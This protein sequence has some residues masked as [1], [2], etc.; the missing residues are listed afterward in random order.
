MNCSHDR[1]SENLS[2][3]SIALHCVTAFIVPAAT[4]A[5][6]ALVIVALCLWQA[7][8]RRC[9][10]SSMP[11]CEPLLGPSSPLLPISLPLLHLRLL[12][13]PPSPP[14]PVEEIMASSPDESEVITDISHPP[15]SPALEA[16]KR[17]VRFA[18]TVSL[19]IINASS[20]PADLHRQDFYRDEESGHR[21]H[22]RHCCKCSSRSYQYEWMSVNVLPR[23]PTATII[24]Y[25]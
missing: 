17:T 25:Y 20:P 14:P 7:A 24:S 23:D 8:T 1:E 18:S 21:N 22:H 15:R 5:L 3:T 6:V 2:F 10:P 19:R 12:S 4:A 16:A 13:L 11:P 9:C